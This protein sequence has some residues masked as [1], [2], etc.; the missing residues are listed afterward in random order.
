MLIKIIISILPW[1]M[2]RPLLVY[3]FK[4]NIHPTARI[5]LSW[6]YPNMLIMNAN[7]KIGHFNT[8]L[9]LDHIEIGE[10]SSIARGNWITGFSTKSISKH[11]AHQKSR[12]SALLIGN[13]SAITKNH[14]IDCTNII[15]IGNFTTVAGYQSQLLT[16]SIDIYENRQDS[17]PIT[18]GD[19]CFVG[20]NVVILGGA[21]LPSYSVLGAKSLLNKPYTEMYK[22]YGGIP[23]RQLTEIPCDAKYFQRQ[24]GFVY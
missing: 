11:F 18:I 13:H 17:H 6:I 4:Y 12:F 19:Y 2:K 22:M 24:K 10:Y 9:H 1:Y 3:F 5:G 20:T 7:S 21:V 23:A 14:H 16:H 15:T 8:A